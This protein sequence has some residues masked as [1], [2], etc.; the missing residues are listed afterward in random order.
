MAP[1][2]FAAARFILE[3]PNTDRKTRS[4]EEA[5]AYSDEALAL[6]RGLGKSGRRGL[7]FALYL[8]PT[9]DP[10]LKKH[11]WKKASPFLKKMKINFTCLNACYGWE[12]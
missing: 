7:A 1:G 3:F 11:S 12:I 5:K 2:I 8:K 6:F 9:I 4:G 10:A